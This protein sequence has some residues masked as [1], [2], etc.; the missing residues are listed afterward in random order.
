MNKIPTRQG[1]IRSPLAASSPRI[2][3]VMDI[4]NGVVVRAIAGRREEYKP[5]VSKLTTSTEPLAVAEALRDF[6]GTDELYVADLDAIQG[7]GNNRSILEGLVKKGFKLWVDAGLREAIDAYSLLQSGIKV[8]VGGLETMTCFQL[9]HT[10]DLYGE[11]AAVCVDLRDGRPVRNEAGW[12]ETSEL[13]IDSLIQTFEIWRLIILDLGRV[14][15]SS[16]IGTETL[17]RRVKS[18]RPE[19]ELVAGGGIRGPEDL[20]ALAEAGVDAV[21]IA[22]ALHDGKFGLPGAPL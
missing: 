8:V 3:P 10:A 9:G 7:A 12:T 11:R 13:L 22:S 1:T 6:V 16:G 14:G 19:I 21:L 5:L 18:E 4:M 2:I 15:T 17:F 20:P